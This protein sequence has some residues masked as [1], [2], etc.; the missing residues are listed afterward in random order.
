MLKNDRMRHQ[1]KTDVMSGHIV[2][3]W[4]RQMP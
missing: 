2:E 3:W 1:F 4:L